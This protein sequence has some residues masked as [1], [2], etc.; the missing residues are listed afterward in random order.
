MGVSWSL[1]YPDHTGTH[2]WAVGTQVGQKQCP[3]SG[4]CKT[5]LLLCPSSCF[6]VFGTA[7]LPPMASLHPWM[8]QTPGTGMAVLDSLAHN[9]N[10]H[11]S[12]PNADGDSTT[13]LLHCRGAWK[14]RGPTHPHPSRMTLLIPPAQICCNEEKIPVPDWH[15]E[16]DIPKCG[17]H[18]FPFSFPS[19]YLHIRNNYGTDLVIS[20]GDKLCKLWLLIRSFLGTQTIFSTSSWVSWFAL[21]CAISWRAPGLKFWLFLEFCEITGEKTNLGAGGYT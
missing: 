8:C 19:H 15:V 2:K 17:F 13:K 18:P 6:Q 3:F 14:S 12:H 5:F 11:F 1:F 20:P 4:T 16:S 10:L 9:V 21:N 7:Q